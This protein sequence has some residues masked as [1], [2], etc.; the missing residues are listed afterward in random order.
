MTH[1][2]LFR[3]FKVLIPLSAQEE[4][5]KE[6]TMPHIFGLYPA[7]S[8]MPGCGISN[9][10]TCTTLHQSPGVLLSLLMLVWPLLDSEYGQSWHRKN[11]LRSIFAILQ[12]FIESLCFKYI[13][14]FLLS[15][16]RLGI[17]KKK[18]QKLKPV[19]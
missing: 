2:C 1:I 9:P 10:P 12:S 8:P 19:F 15:H 18:K 5:K 14:F 7:L 17:L 13:L 16:S 3:E 4:Q 6:T 11:N